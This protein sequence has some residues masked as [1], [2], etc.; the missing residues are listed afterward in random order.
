MT[1][2]QN[3]KLPLFHLLFPLITTIVLLGGNMCL[4]GGKASH[5]P[6]QIVFLLGAIMSLVIN[7]HRGISWSKIKASMISNMQPILPTFIFL[8]I[9]A[10]MSATWLLSGIMPSIIYYGLYLLKPRLFLVTTLLLCAIV[11]V[12][13]GSSWATIA[14]I[15]VAMLG[16]GKALGWSDGIVAGAIISGAYFGDKLSP[17]SETTVMAASV[18]NTNI[19]K[20][21]NR[22]MRTALPTL[23]LVMFI[24]W[25]IGFTEGNLVVG[26]LA[27]RE[28]MCAYLKNKFT[29][30]PWLFVVPLLVFVLILLRVSPLI[31]LSVGALLGIVVIGWVRPP[32]YIGLIGSENL[33]SYMAIKKL[34][35]FVLLGGTLPM[36]G[37]LLLSDLMSTGGLIGMMPTITLILT[38]IV[39]GAAL[40]ATNT[41]TILANRFLET[42]SYGG[43]MT[44]TTLTGIFLNLT[45][46]DQ[47]L[48]ILLGGKIY[49]TVFKKQQIPSEHLSSALEDSITVTSPLIPWNTCGAAQASVLGVPTLMYL[50][51]AFFNIITPLF[52]ILLGFLDSRKIQKSKGK[53]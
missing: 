30:T 50:P 4:L 38:A 41:I 32:S 17:L 5:G 2:Q 26:P 45:V 37:N 25:I 7:R 15:G 12:A 22:M 44:Y 34:L 27:E 31:T 16:I 35:K 8:L 23:L 52:S 10:A 28:A 20:H 14:T 13:T 43:L 36:E 18:T 9:V 51:F 19:Y 46:A 3:K 47:Y 29:I 33:L 53:S 6:N 11:S 49:T 39:L 48:A 1:Q 24:F 42:G 21:I 40:E